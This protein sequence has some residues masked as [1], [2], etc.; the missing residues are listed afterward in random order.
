L[1]PKGSGKTPGSGRKA[2]TP[3]KATADI[4]ALAQAA[5]PA[6]FAKAIGL[7]GSAKSEQAQLKAIE[8]ILDRA[9]GKAHTTAEVNIPRGV[10]DLSTAEILRILTAH[11]VVGDETG[12][13]EPERLH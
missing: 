5:A 3:N 2:G 13:E 7:A 8:I 11:G 6:A 4:K 1:R 10:R 9:Y 12:L